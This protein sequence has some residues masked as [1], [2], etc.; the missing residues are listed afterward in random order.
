MATP[1]SSAIIRIVAAT[2]SLFVPKIKI[3]SWYAK[4]FKTRRQAV[5]SRRSRHVSPS[6]LYQ[7][8]EVAAQTNSASITFLS[9]SELVLRLVLR[10]HMMRAGKLVMRNFRQRK[11]SW[12]RLEEKTNKQGCTASHSLNYLQGVDD[13][14]HKIS[15]ISFVDTGYR[16]LDELT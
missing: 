10:Y 12:E 8:S 1:Y 5:V 16:H 11:H 9:R 4:G 13:F 6:H 7:L 15:D 14:P 2:T 3:F